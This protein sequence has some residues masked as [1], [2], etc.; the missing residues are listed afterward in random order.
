MKDKPDFSKMAEP[1][2]IRRIESN[3]PGVKHFIYPGLKDYVAGCEKIWNDFVVPRDAK[4]ADLQASRDLLAS[5]YNDQLLQISRLKSELEESKKSEKSTYALMLSGEQRGTDKCK[6]EVVELE[7]ELDYWKLGY[8]NQAIQFGD[9]QS[10]LDK[11]KEISN[12][13]TVSSD[14]RPGST[15]IYI[16]KHPNGGH[17]IFYEETDQEDAFYCCVNNVRVFI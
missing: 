4:I 17:V 6:E 14:F 5:T 10:E 9:L 12:G 13:H 11:A 1:I 15:A 16:G 7:K 3:V 8:H 2:Y